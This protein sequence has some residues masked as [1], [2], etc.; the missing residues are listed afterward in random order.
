MQGK[1]AANVNKKDIYKIVKLGRRLLGVR[2]GMGLDVC[3]LL[4]ASSEVALEMTKNGWNYE[5]SYEKFVDD[6]RGEAKKIGSDFGS[7]L[8]VK[9][10]K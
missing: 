9:V 2:D 6:V 1:V 5:G 7:Y 4:L 8:R 3:L 10:Q